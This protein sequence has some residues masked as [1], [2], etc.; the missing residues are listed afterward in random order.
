MRGLVMW[1][2]IELPHIQVVGN[3]PHL[4]KTFG[5]AQFEEQLNSKFI[6]RRQGRRLRSDLHTSGF[7]MPSERM[8]DGS[9]SSTALCACMYFYSVYNFYIS[10][11]RFPWC[12]FRRP[13]I[14]CAPNRT[15]GFQIPWRSHLYKRPY[16]SYS[17]LFNR[18]D[19]LISWPAIVGPVVTPH[20]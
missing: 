19:D 16:K 3:A 1:K 10:S 8:I 13:R 11:S 17:L 12:R 15:G 20:V 14:L 5:Q 6:S 7:R 9:N 4:S 18:R 2:M